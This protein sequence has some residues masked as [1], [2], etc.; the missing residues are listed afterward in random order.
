MDP[1]REGFK[2][3]TAGLGASDNPHDPTTPEHFCWE[4][5]WLNAQL[6]ESRNPTR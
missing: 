1:Y 5:G 2:A 3:F 6:E 4:D